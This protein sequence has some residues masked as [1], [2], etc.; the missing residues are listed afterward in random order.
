M[1]LWLLDEDLWFPDPTE[2]TE[3]GLLAV[4]GDLRPERMLLAYQNGIFPWYSA[5]DP[6]LWWS[7]DPR[8][9]LFP[10]QLKVSHSMRPLLNRNE[11]DFRRDTAFEAVMRACAEVARSGENG[12]WIQEEMIQSYCL[13][14]KLGY[15][16]SAEA[17]KDGELVGGLYGVRLGKVF[18][19][20]SM[21]S[22]KSNA[23]K[24]AFVKLVRELQNEGVTMIDCQMHTGHLER[25]GAQHIPRKQFLELLKSAVL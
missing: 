16:H 5:E 10:A 9:V 14:H 20:E 12:T 21:F 2:A 13:L 22:R 25:F 11:F 1:A 6:L 17:W 18:F 23:S 8:F 3:D 19:G 15:A 4:G 7:P 24:F